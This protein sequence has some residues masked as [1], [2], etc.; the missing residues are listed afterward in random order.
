MEHTLYHFV[1]EFYD[2][3]V[4]PMSRA[5]KDAMKGSWPVYPTAYQTMDGTQF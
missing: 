5:E 3:W 4:Q 2:E 1:D